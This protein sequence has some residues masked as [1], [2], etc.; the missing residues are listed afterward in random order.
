MSSDSLKVHAAGSA[1][2]APLS[3]GTL[4]LYGNRI[5][6]YVYRVRLVL[7]A[8][9]IPH[10]IVNIHLRSKP[11]WYLA[12]N[13][14]GKVPAIEF[15]DNILYESL[16]VAD[17]LDTAF[18]QTKLWS[19]DPLEI[20]KGR[21]IIERNAKLAGINGKGFHGEP[22]FD[23][24]FVELDYYEK[25]LKKLD[26]PYFC[27]AKPGMVDFMIYPIFETALN[28][29]AE[30]LEGEGRPILSKV[31]RPNLRAW[32]ENMQ[33]NPTVKKERL[34]QDIWKKIIATFK[35]G[36]VDFDIGLGE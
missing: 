12:E 34:P 15:D 20:A 6:P 35:T 16:I 17:Y 29:Y 21:I 14:E 9:N 28:L 7:A 26:K 18:P 33:N 22:D 4:R 3:K 30:K 25:A 36:N 27:G 10:E 24:L 32:I 8:K 13:P 11:E 23:E 31:E 19:S 5:C 1:E 2:P